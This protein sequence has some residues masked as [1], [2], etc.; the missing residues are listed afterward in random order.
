MAYTHPGATTENGGASAPHSI[1]LK[2]MSQR[3]IDILIAQAMGNCLYQPGSGEPTGRPV[4]TTDRY[5]ASVAETISTGT[6]FNLVMGFSYSALW[7]LA[8]NCTEM[9]QALMHN[10]NPQNGGTIITGSGT[11][12][13]AH[14][15][16]I[17]LAK[18]YNGHD[19]DYLSEGLNSPRIQSVPRPVILTPINA[20]FAIV[21]AA[22]SIGLGQGSIRY[23]GVDSEFRADVDSMKEAIRAAHESGERIIVSFGIAGD[24]EHGTLERISTL[25]TVL[26]ECCEQGCGEREGYIPPILVDASCQWLNSSVSGTSE[27]WD[28]RNPGV[29]GIVADPHK[30]E[31]PF[32][33]SLLL[34][35][36]LKELEPLA[37]NS[38]FSGV[39]P[40]HDK[41][42]LEVQANLLT[43]RGGAPI[44]ALYAYLL[45][46]GMQG[47]I[48]K[49]A[50]IN[51]LVG[52]LRDYIVE[53]PYYKLVCEPHSSV[54]S[55]VSTHP[56]PDANFKTALKIN[57]NQDDSLFIAYSPIMRA[58][59]PEELQRGLTP[60]CREFDGLHAHFMEHNTPQ[61]LQ[62]LIRRLDE[63]GRQLRAELSH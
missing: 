47:L 59:T 26:A 7:A 36:D 34:L 58:R 18:Y 56:H 30:S 43:S 24:T 55:F 22:Q 50:T 19:I 61:G 41:R 3:T 62:K 29:W 60:E 5:A 6:N 27:L 2:G 12:S 17:A 16:Q 49:R 10:P 39:Q 11:Q 46:Q 51:E 15:F 20:N 9:V 42:T 48:K 14:A 54:V 38:A 8:E 63:V 13:I 45:N 32:N 44:I 31:L 35:R 57:G 21:K 1:Q 28:F 33:L 40:I 23:Y 53:S 4:T 52:N 37:P 25:E